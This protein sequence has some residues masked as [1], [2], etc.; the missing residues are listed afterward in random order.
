MGGSS[1]EDLE[2]FRDYLEDSFVVLVIDSA[3]M[4]GYLITLIS[5]Q[6]PGRIFSVWVYLLG[7][8][9]YELR[10]FEESRQFSPSQVGTIADQFQQALRD[11]S[12]SI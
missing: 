5:Q 9:E 6:K 10:G 12:H 3:P 7:I 1:L 4:G 11:T 2:S 8:G